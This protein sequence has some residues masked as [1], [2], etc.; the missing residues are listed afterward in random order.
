[1]SSVALNILENQKTDD[2][3]SVSC[4]K[5][6]FCLREEYDE[7]TLLLIIHNLKELFYNQLGGKVK[8]Q[9]AGRYTVVNDFKQLSTLLTN[10]LKSKRKSLNVNYSY[11]GA[12]YGR[13][14]HIEPSLQEICRPIRHSVAKDIY[15]DVDVKNAHPLFVLKYCEATGFSHP[16]LKE[17]VEGDREAFLASII[18]LK[19][20][21]RNEDEKGRVS[22][23][24]AVIDGR[25]A[26]K[27]YFLQLLNGGG[28]GATGHKKLDAF[29]TRHRQFLNRFFDEPSNSKYAERAKQ[30]AKKKD[31]DNA[32]GSALNYYMC[33][34]EN[35][36]LG[37]ME[38]FLQ[39]E[40]VEYGTLCFDGLMIYKRDVPDCE[41]LLR[42]MEV[43]LAEK[44]GFA[45]CLTE[46]KMDEAL[47]L[48]GYELKDDWIEQYSWEEYENM[49]SFERAFTEAK[50]TD[51]VRV[52]A[53]H[54][55]GVIGLKEVG[56]RTEEEKAF[57]KVVSDD[58]GRRNVAE[59]L[60]ISGGE[61]RSEEH[62]NE[63]EFLGP[64][65][66]V[67][68]RA[69][70]GRGK[71]TAS[72]KHIRAGKYDSVVV[73]TPRQSYATSI[74]AR[75]K[76]AFGTEFD[77]KLYLDMKPAD[78]KNTRYLVIQ[79]ESLH[80]LESIVWGNTLVL[81]DEIESVLAQMT[82]RQTHKEAIDRNFAVLKRLLQTAKKLL[83]MDAFVSDRTLGLLRD[84]NIS[85]RFFNYTKPLATRRAI[86]LY[87]K[88]ETGANGKKEK[89]KAF[90]VL[91]SKIIVSLSE[92]KRVFF[93]CSSRDKLQ[94][95]VQTVRT[96][97]A[98]NELRAEVGLGE[99]LVKMYVGGGKTLKTSV[100]EEWR[101]TR[102][103][104]TTSTITVG[105]NFDVEGVFN[106]LFVYGSASSGNFVRDIFQASYRVRHFTDSLMYYALDPKQIGG[107]KYPED[108]KGVDDYVEK[109]REM[110]LGNLTWGEMA[111]AKSAEPWVRNLVVYTNWERSLSIKRMEIL[112]DAYLSACSYVKVAAEEELYEELDDTSLEE[113]ETVPP[114]A[115]IQEILD[116]T[117]EELKEKQKKKQIT[118]TERLLLLK[119]YFLKCFDTA[120]TGAVLETL[121]EL[122]NGFGGQ[123]RFSNMITEKG[124]LNGTYYVEDIS[125]GATTV[126]LMNNDRMKLRTILDLCKRLG[127]RNSQEAAVVPRDKID[128]ITTWLKEEGTYEKLGKTFGFDDRRADKKKKEEEISSEA[129]VKMITKVFNSW[130]YSEFK[131]G[132]RRQK[133]VG[134]K[135]IDL[136]DFEIKPKAI[137]GLDSCLYSVVRTRGAVNDEAERRAQRLLREETESDEEDE[138]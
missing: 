19:I 64:E 21:K 46:K 27:A 78:Y 2:V 36:V 68:I 94:Q 61:E 119:F 137:D 135:R 116:E 98:L 92:G 118:Q 125:M 136:S 18:G 26:A 114:C 60:Q 113:G 35:I 6:L 58:Y 76:E 9:S 131:R 90:H 8:I 34:Q 37:H 100:D 77:F 74:H 129:T 132:K 86:R 22:I 20:Q 127:V 31:W 23:V 28:K 56:E 1:M 25:D 111:R 79:V 24:D 17:Y 91:V 63:R 95:A 126:E 62:V 48:D 3:K 81:G 49:S 51:F 7:D 82:V 117:A 71:T 128:E 133:R 53:Y 39:S 13:R 87:D 14:F 73:L 122:W 55:A 85:F 15:Y 130:G 134:E 10:L 80:Y 104:A 41:S 42:R 97:P 52:Q 30:A 54:E 70:L 43:Y 102:L 109:E 75:L 40:G 121:W 106:E 69:G 101:D 59:L 44:M 103:V 120:P 83:F 67:V 11:K 4:F 65:R 5:P 89:K 88:V 72:F 47:A 84:L 123:K 33:E 12:D 112:F 110:R 115:N 16:I 107:F 96:S 105:I 38:V 93:F 32:R 29:Y 50:S 108:K 138:E 45:I 57:L 99:R 124:V 66:A